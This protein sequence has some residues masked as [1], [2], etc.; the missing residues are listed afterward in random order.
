MFNAMAIARIGAGLEKDRLPA[1]GQYAEGED[2]GKLRN[3]EVPL[4]LASKRRTC[5]AVN[6]RHIGIVGF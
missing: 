6:A 4:S 5:E 2:Y 3:T 1:D